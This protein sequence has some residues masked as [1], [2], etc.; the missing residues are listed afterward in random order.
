MGILRGVPG[1]THLERMSG[2]ATLSMTWCPGV[3]VVTT[4]TSVCFRLWLQV[5]LV[6][7]TLD[8]KV[9]SLIYSQFNRRGRQVMT[10]WG[11]A[12]LGVGFQGLL[13][14]NL[15]LSG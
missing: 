5:S 14:I 9:F 2:A 4:P 12:K 13:T 10:E 6:L 7:S 15:L 1:L 8:P 3:M 11:K